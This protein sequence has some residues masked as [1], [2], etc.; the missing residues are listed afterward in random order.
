MASVA[1][2]GFVVLVA[3]LA[4]GFAAFPDV[5]GGALAPLLALLGD[6]VVV[7]GRRLPRVVF[8]VALFLTLLAV[9]VVGTVAVAR[10]G[11]EVARSAGPRTQRLVRAVTPS[12]PVGKMAVGV[13]FITLFLLGSVWSL[14]AVVGDIT[15]N[16][17]FGEAD[18]LAG[19]TESVD[20]IQMSAA[21]IVAGGPATGPSEDARAYDRPTPDA[22]SDRLKDS[23]ERA[24]ETPDGVAL[25]DA[26]PRRKDLYVQVS[27]GGG[28]IP[29]S[30]AE[31]AQLR[32]IWAQMPVENPDGSTGVRLHIDDQR[33]DGGGLGTTVSMSA[34]R[35][36]QVHAYYTDEH[37]G[38]RRC[39]YH[40][41]VVGTVTRDGADGAATTP[42]YAAVVDG[43]RRDYGGEYT[44]RVHVIT[45]ELLHNVAGQFTAD[46]HVSRGWLSPTTSPNDAFLSD[47]TATHLSENGFA[48]S[49]YFQTELCGETAE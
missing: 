6:G 22:D 12:T 37:V 49:G 11:Y 5:V 24:G 4:V 29:L 26:D 45:H 30:D 42:G 27:Y 25:P 2:E 17:A 48:G 20:P 15:E 35:Y 8:L 7:A 13:G 3:V 23:W 36:E 33:P 31:K 47:R 38:D 46:G 18:D 9:A 16:E 21:D 19:S 39:R 14:P 41:V 10:V 28:M 43:E 34:G 40:Q 44:A 1:E 32:E